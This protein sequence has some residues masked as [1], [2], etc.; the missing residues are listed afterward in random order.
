TSLHP[1]R[2]HLFQNYPNPFNPS[3]IIRY[4][5]EPL[6]SGRVETLHLKVFD[7]TGREIA[8]LVNS[9]TPPGEYSVTWKPGAISSGI[10]FYRLTYGSFVELKKMI[11]VK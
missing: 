3:T 7:L 10:Y 6:K 2:A 1:E 5:V 8:D 9:P 4:S 11:F